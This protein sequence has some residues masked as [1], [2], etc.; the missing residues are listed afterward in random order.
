MTHRAFDRDAADVPTSP[1]NQRAEPSATLEA[2]DD[3]ALV[4]EFKLAAILEPTEDAGG[5]G[6]LGHYRIVDQIGCG[7]MGLVL[8]GE[9]TKLERRAALK[10]MKPALAANPKSRERFLREARAAAKLQ[11][12]NV[13]PILHICDDGPAPFFAMPYLPG[14][15][16]SAA[17]A[18]ENTLSIAEA[19][20]IAKEAALG[21]EAA[22]VQGLIHRDIKPS[23][24]WLE[25]PGRRVRIL[26]FGLA[27]QAFASQALTSSGQ[28]IGTP[29][30]MAPEQAAAGPIDQR[31]DLFSLGAVLYRM[32]S[33]TQP[34][35]GG[36]IIETLHL[37]ANKNVPP[38]KSV[39]DVPLELSQLTQRML[40]RDP[41]KRP[42]NAREVIIQL[43]NIE[44]QLC[45]T[46]STGVTRQWQ[47][48][49]GIAIGVAA[50]AFTFEWFFPIFRAKP[51]D[52][53]VGVDE[54]KPTAVMPA[55]ERE[56]LNSVIAELLR[57]NPDYEGHHVPR[58]VKG[59]LIAVTIES[60][61]LVDLRPLGQLTDLRTLKVL[62]KLNKPSKLAT[63]QGLK[64]LQLHELDVGYH[65]KIANLEPI[66][67][68]PLTRL[69]IFQ[70]GVRDLSP[71]SGMK[72]RDL[73]CSRTKVDDIGPLR[74]MPLEILVIDNTGVANLEPLRNAP[75]KTLYV[76]QTRVRD[77]APLVNT[78]LEQLFLDFDAGMHAAALSQIKTLMKINNKPAGNFLQSN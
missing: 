77:I 56:K 17:L 3:A 52:Y 55:N 47:Q 66:R 48:W 57:I 8:L 5:L 41:E 37:L 61:N 50:L 36:D 31:S 27:R 68:M 14:L 10:V 65:P 7:G 42:A 67:G 46:R 34:F 18:A 11:H 21:L 70:T 16:L 78:P 38:L 40:E 69:S 75:L 23:N 63:L 43:E 30:Y 73:C 26:D 58:F 4:Q 76:N 19:V 51:G 54:F 6:R 20:R 72:L 35:K 44:S 71:L 28:L 60:C 32:I 59:K 39:V 15:S 64:G 9:D 53:K 2:G 22:H 12:D 49:V 62:G 45:S 29:A 74:G 24:L 1:D 33:G 25:G 13:M